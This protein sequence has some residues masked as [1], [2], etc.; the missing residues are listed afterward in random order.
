MKGCSYLKKFIS[1]ILLNIFFVFFLSS[2]KDIQNIQ[3]VPVSNKPIVYS[4]FYAMYDLTQKIG[5]DNIELYNMLSSGIEPHDFEPTANDIIKLENADVFVYNGANME[6]WVDKVLNSLQSDKLITVEASSNV[7][8]ISDEQKSDPHVWLSP[9]NAKI[10]ADNIKK[11]LIKADP[12]H[13]DSYEKNYND[14][15]LELDALDKEYSLTLNSLPK[16]DIVVAHRAYSYL[17]KEYGLNQISINGISPD[18]EPDPSTM[19]NTI[20]YCK[21]HNVNTI[22]FEEMISPKTAQVI[23]NEIGAEVSVLNP[24]ESLSEDEIVSNDDYFSI[25]RKNLIALKG[26]LS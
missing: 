22:F 4:S 7:E 5:K 9:K 18:T 26:A 3:N 11:A 12:Q 23:A 2:C 20:E 21:K 15:A 8:L 13:A 10:E 1:I 19:A 16:K 17:C 24:L 14:L 25:M 6:H